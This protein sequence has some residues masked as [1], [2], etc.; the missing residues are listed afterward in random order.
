[1]RPVVCMITDRR[2]FGPDAEDA[3]VNRVAAAA[4]GGVHLVQ[5][6][7]RD[8]TDGALLVL[9]ARTLDAVRG[10]GAR[11]LVNDRA[12]VA[13]AAGA[14]GVH[15]RS[16]SPDAMR[17]RAVSP[18]HFLIGRSVHD[19]EEVHR[20]LDEGGIDYLLFGTTFGTAS[21]P[22]RPA[23]GIEALAEAVKTAARLP[24]LAVGGVTLETIGQLPATGCSGFAAIGHFAGGSEDDLAASVTAALAAWDN[25]G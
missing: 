2:R 3:L 6:R 21:K 14:H 20:A 15:L 4:R 10:T 9:V 22:G 12:D 25:S 18:P 1:M 8:M 23:A 24:V 16:D 17:V 5:I 11:I 19:R 13:I 7:E